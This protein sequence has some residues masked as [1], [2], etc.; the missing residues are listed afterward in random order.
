MC[1]KA[2]SAVR[3]RS[4][5]LRRQ[6]GH[7]DTDKIHGALS[8]LQLPP[9]TLGRVRLLCLLFPGYLRSAYTNSSSKFRTYTTSRMSSHHSHNQRIYTAVRMM[10]HIAPTSSGHRV[11]A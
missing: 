7:D 11:I 2:Q 9:L 10:S 8:Y 5:S 1:P 4:A 3:Q 6:A